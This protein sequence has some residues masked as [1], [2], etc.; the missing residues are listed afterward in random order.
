MKY[1][2]LMQLQNFFSQFKKIDFI[3]RI[4]DNILEL[5][6]DR[7]RFIFDLTRGMSAIYTAKLMSKNYNAPF[8]FML[9]KY[10]NNA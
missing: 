6:F 5:S 9:K 2:E 3:K 1:T 10:F 8:D 4:N 7:E